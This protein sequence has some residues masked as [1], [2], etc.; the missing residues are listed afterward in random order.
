MKKLYFLSV[1]LFFSGCS[2]NNEEIEDIE[3]PVGKLVDA[4]IGVSMGDNSVSRAYLGEVTE[5]VDRDGH[6]LGIYSIAHN[7]E[8][9]D[10]MYITDYL[11][12]H[13]FE[14]QSN[15]QTTT[16]KGEWA[17]IDQNNAERNGICAIFPQGS[18]TGDVTV[19]ENRPSMYFNLP[20]EQTPYVR[21]SQLSYDRAAGLAFACANNKSDNL[22]FMPVVSYLY[23]Y[24]KEATC[25]ITSDDV[26]IAGAYT[27]TYS[28]QYGTGTNTAGTDY[29][30]AEGLD[31]FLS[32]EATEKKIICHGRQIP[33]H[34]NAFQDA[35]F[36]GLGYEYI[37]AVKPGSYAAKSL[38]I[39]PEGATKP[40]K[41][42]S[43]TL[44]PSEVYFIGCVDA[45]TTN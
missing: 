11:G 42:P 41:S 18:V 34:S 45:P 37:I 38:V 15:G 5:E 29:N 14:V 31:K 26:A 32:Y 12:K 28:G 8:K 24:S 19:T 43:L 40:C 10:Q 4:I 6:G 30:T 9:Y 17:A 35:G 2:G 27:V 13:S 39:T 36:N 22:W 7:F 33:N 44:I 21:N 20:T 1:L 23:F 3:K 16:I 25:T